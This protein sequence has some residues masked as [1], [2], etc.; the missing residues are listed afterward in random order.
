MSYSALGSWEFLSQALVGRKPATGVE[1]WSV[2]EGDTVL[3]QGLV[4]V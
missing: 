3:A 1:E 2:G 4:W